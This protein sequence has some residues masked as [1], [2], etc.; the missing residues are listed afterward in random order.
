MLRRDESQDL[1][2]SY[3]ASEFSN[4]CELKRLKK[5]AEKKPERCQPDYISK[6]ES[7]AE[8]SIIQLNHS[9]SDQN[10][11]QIERQDEASLDIDCLHRN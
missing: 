3:E 6:F 8:N 10:S 4:R 5:L 11:L 9:R 1:S 2:S 7:S